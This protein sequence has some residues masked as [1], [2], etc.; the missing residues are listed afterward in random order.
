MRL[1]KT[2]KALLSQWLKTELQDLTR[3]FAKAATY[4]AA[5]MCD[6]DYQRIVKVILFFVRQYVFLLAWFLFALQYISQVSTLWLITI[7]W[8]KVERFTLIKHLFFFFWF[9]SPP[10]SL[11]VVQHC[12]NYNVITTHTQR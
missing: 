4:R 7:V 3:T 11:G 12:Y 5:Y 1:F 2:A 8:L 6:V 9:L 10:C